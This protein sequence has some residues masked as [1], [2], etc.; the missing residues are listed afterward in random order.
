MK[1]DIRGLIISDEKVE[2]DWLE[3]ELRSAGF[4][5]IFSASTSVPIRHFEGYA[6]SF[7]LLGPSVPTLITLKLIHRIKIVDPGVSVFLTSQEEDLAPVLDNGP[8]EGIHRLTLGKEPAKTAEKIQQGLAQRNDL[9]KGPEFPV[10]IGI[11]PSI[12]KIR[13]KVRRISDKDI[14]VL[15][16]GESGTGKE[17]I[18]RSLH[19]FSSRRNQPLVKINCGALPEDLLESE[20]FGYQRGAFTGAQRDKP[21]RLEMA[22]G[23]TLFIDEIG[24]LPL[25]SQVKFL[26]ILEDKSFSRLGGVRDKIVN[27]RVV[28]ATNSDLWTMVRE[29]KFRKD[30]YYRLNVFRIEAPPLRDRPE[31]IPLLADYFINKFCYENNR[32]PLDIPA[33]VI[34]LLQ[35]YRWPGNVRE[36]ENMVR[37]AMINQEWDFLF[38]VLDVDPDLGT[39]RQEWQFISNPLSRDLGKSG[40]E[41]FFSGDDFSLRNVAKRYVAEVERKAIIE[42]LKRTRW[43]RR[44]AA[45]LLDISYKTLLNRIREYRINQGS[46]L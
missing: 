21:G 44:K 6:P 24:N 25:T 38:E 7:A 4:S 30:L 42:A 3:A 1:D 35:R 43:N 9:S 8:F 22:H 32:D 45:R 37:R 11:S 46:T 17:L 18:A 29:G 28:A 10:L 2:L 39:S 36:L 40:I 34:T 15:I 41:Y 26:Q 31:D 5:A 19:Y 20:V 13:E 27:A 12:Q 16:T 23:G 14:T 33:N